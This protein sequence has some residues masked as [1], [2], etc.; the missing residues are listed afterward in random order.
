MGGTEA[1]IAGLGF[2]QSIASA[3]SQAKQQSQAERA[4]ARAA[5]ER[6]DAQRR[7]ED[8]ERARQIEDRN[9]GIEDNNRRIDGLRR[10]QSRLDA[11]RRDQLKRA[12]ATQRARFG[13][14][15]LSSAGGSAR[16]ILN[17]LISESDRE[18]RETASDTRRGIEDLTRVNAQ[19]V[20]DSAAAFA[21]E[22]DAR[23]RAE[24]F[25]KDQENLLTRRNGRSLLADGLGTAQRVV[26]TFNKGVGFARSLI[27]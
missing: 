6:L 21:F 15:G 23:A 26:G 1:I 16:A 5:Q 2:A 9:R 19:R 3:A 4:Q 11:Q 27:S 14:S 25:R 22:D 12:L 8:F 13:A 17:G 7:A 24:R 10:I 20:S 18:G